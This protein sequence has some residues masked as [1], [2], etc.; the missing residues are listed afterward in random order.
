MYKEET[1]ERQ[2]MIDVGPSL[3]GARHDNIEAASWWAEPDAYRKNTANKVARLYKVAAN[4]M[5]TLDEFYAG[6]AVSASQ[7][8]PILERAIDAEVRAPG[9]GK[10]GLGA[11]RQ[12]L[13]ESVSSRDLKT[14]N[15][16]LDLLHFAGWLPS[17]LALQ[18]VEKSEVGAT[19]AT[20]RAAEIL[21]KAVVAVRDTPPGT[22]RL[23]KFR[24]LLKSAHE[25]GEQLAENLP[26]ST[27]A[28]FDQ[29]AWMLMYRALL[30][31]GARYVF[32][33]LF[34][35]ALQV[36]DLFSPPPPF[37][38]S[39]Q[40]VSPLLLRQVPPPPT[41]A[42]PPVPR[43]KPRADSLIPPPSPPDWG[44]LERPGS[45]HHQ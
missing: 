36:Y 32:G 45:R 15:R 9:A 37:V 16:A 2:A 19:E 43:Q 27:D 44:V 33:D 8:L 22:S 5:K 24:M 34:G 11:A 28:R 6:K 23:N 39:P 14:S 13:E 25:W 42:P 12:L 21:R 4:V 1:R 31:L 38:D 30:G 26:S 3:A 35:D 17:V 40:P 20:R 10:A 41:E 18:G 29:Q 7:I